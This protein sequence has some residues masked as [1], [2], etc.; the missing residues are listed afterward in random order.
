M[1][2]KKERST[3]WLAPFPLG[4]ETRLIT[5]L[6]PSYLTTHEVRC[7]GTIPLSWY[8][9]HA[10]GHHMV[11]YPC[12]GDIFISCV[13]PWYHTHAMVPYS[14]LGLSRGTTTIPW[15]HIHIDGHRMV[16]HPCHGVIF[17]FL[18]IPWYHT[19][20]MVP[21]SLHLSPPTLQFMRSQAMVPYPWHGSSYGTIP[22]PWCHIHVMGYLM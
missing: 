14:Y 22:I 7:H 3:L 4:S 9:N 16:P 12:H 19:H 5:S 2:P 20:A 10:M 15:C 6:I 21:S 17:I 11:I 8:H 1:T 18:V 13:I